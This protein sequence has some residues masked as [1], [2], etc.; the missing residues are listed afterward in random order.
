MSGLNTKGV[1]RAN[2]KQQ[3]EM[4]THLNQNREEK[5]M[6]LAL[7]NSHHLLSGTEVF[8]SKHFAEFKQSASDYYL[9]TELT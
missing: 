4:V 7:I 6:A 5:Y 1:R 2:L 8:K 3:G 9:M